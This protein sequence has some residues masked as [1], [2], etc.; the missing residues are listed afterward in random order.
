MTVTKSSR[1]CANLRHAPGAAAEKEISQLCEFA[2]S[3]MAPWDVS[4]WMEKYKQ[5]K[6]S[7]S[8]EELRQYFPAQTTVNGLFK[9][10]ERLYGIRLESRDD[11]PTWHEDVR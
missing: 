9:L 3:A 8:N 2:G 11:V 5:K 1:S 6:Y 7:V 10:A 4:Y